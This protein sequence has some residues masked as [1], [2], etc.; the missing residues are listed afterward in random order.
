M[1]KRKEG[2]SKM[3]DVELRK[4]KKQ[5]WSNSKGF[6]RLFLRNSKCRS[7]MFNSLVRI[8][9]QKLPMLKHNNLCSKLWL[10]ASKTFLSR[11]RLSNRLTN[12]K[13][14]SSKLKWIKFSKIKC[15]ISSKCSPRAFQTSKWISNKRSSRSCQGK[16]LTKCLNSM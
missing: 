12:S 7:K 15:K 13:Q 5:N 8:N 14:P 10:V 9:S 4:K 16:L 3:Q 6:S 1:T 11:I 2:R